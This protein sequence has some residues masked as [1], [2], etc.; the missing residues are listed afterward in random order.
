M[1]E[2][3]SVPA[4]KRDFLADTPC[5]GW[6]VAALAGDAST[7][8]YDRLTGPMGDTA[9]LMDAGPDA[10]RT[11]PPFLAIAG[12]LARLGL[13]PPPILA[14]SDPPRF[15][16]IG[17]LGP[18]DVAGWLRTHPADEGTLYDAAL[19]VLHR[20][21][22]AP[23]P[24]GLAHLTPDVGA[25]MLEPFFAFHAPQADRP[26]IE[27]AMQDS[28]AH[29]AGAPDTLSLRDFHAENLIWRPER[30]GTDRVG[31]LEFQ[32][33][34]VAPAAYDLISLLRDARRD[35]SAETGAALTVRFADHAG[36]ALAE[37]QAACAVL[38]VQRNLRIL[39]IF[40]R[41]AQRD[42]KRQYL[43]LLP[44]VTGHLRADLA[45]PALARLAPLIEPHLDR[46]MA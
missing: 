27:A 42:G 23:P 24:P 34:F 41:L 26:G 4:Q 28:L 44:R 30:Q 36:Q 17:D 1:A 31:L 8:S 35:V 39:G 3:V 10:A 15:L 16:L 32:D 22:A 6:A 7:R 33:A 29:H 9:I 21:A 46:A 14:Q 37:V 18:M 43:R 2:T 25:A 45:H 11:V 5:A 12:H 40:A 19:D 38:A 13:C 20:I